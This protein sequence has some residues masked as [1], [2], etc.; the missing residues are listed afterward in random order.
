MWTGGQDYESICVST[1][2]TYQ[3]YEEPGGTHLYQSP[4]KAGSWG[5]GFQAWL[6]CNTQGTSEIQKLK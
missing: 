4:V 1:H 2:N 3:N 6:I 5:E